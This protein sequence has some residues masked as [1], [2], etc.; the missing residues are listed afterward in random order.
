MDRYV[1]GNWVVKQGSSGEFI[2][3][4][5]AFTQWSLDNAAGSEDFLLL[6]DAQDPQHFISLGVWRDHESISAWRN[7]PEFATLLG[8]CRELCE[9]F[10][11]V[12]YE[13][14]ARPAAA[15]TA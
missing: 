6:Q 14:V 2:S 1:S 15:R 10:R 7:L 13:L 3:R 8:R 11:G 5:K 12:D 4:W 9:D